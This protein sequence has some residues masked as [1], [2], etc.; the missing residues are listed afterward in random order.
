MSN[1]GLSAYICVPWLI[2]LYLSILRLCVYINIYPEF[3][4]LHFYISVH[5]VNHECRAP[6][7]GWARQF[8]LCLDLQVSPPFSFPVFTENVK[9][10]IG[11]SFH[12][13][14]DFIQGGGISFHTAGSLSTS[15]W[16]L[17][18]NKNYF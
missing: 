12:N 1:L 13:P 11:T 10:F 16:K 15:T 7:F 17:I 8:S 6:Y 5:G 2:C 3:I 18:L 4:C 14:S 9:S